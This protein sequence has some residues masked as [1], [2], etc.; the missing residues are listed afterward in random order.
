MLLHENDVPTTSAAFYVLAFAVAAG[1]VVIGGRLALNEPRGPA[2]RRPPTALTAALGLGTVLVF[3]GLVVPFNGGGTKNGFTNASAILGDRWPEEPWAAL[4]ALA[5]AGA[6]WAAVAL[7][8]RGRRELAA[9]LLIALGA[10]SALV[11][12]R[13]ALVPPDLDP[14]FGSAAP[15]GFMGLAGAILVLLTGLSLA[16]R[17][18]QPS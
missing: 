16:L 5:V 13:Y 1:T 9:G 3:A 4:H 12:V 2:E 15:G 11:W 10:V 8:G 6:A 17:R 7:V 18:L 14:G